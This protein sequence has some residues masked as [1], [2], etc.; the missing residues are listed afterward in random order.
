MRKFWRWLHSDV[1]ILDIIEFILLEMVKMMNFISC[2]F[3]HNKNPGKDR[4]THTQQN[5][6]KY[7]LRNQGD[8]TMD[9]FPLPEKSF[10]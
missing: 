9:I 6:H 7:S 5:Y 10:K 2:A 8:L 3:Y 4:D 1:N